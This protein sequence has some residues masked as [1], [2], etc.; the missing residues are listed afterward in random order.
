MEV[1][2]NPSLNTKCSCGEGE[3]KRGGEGEGMQM[4]GASA[5]SAGFLK[6]EA[7]VMHGGGGRGRGER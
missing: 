1:W 4:T 5:R 7:G 3:R 6:K 2:C